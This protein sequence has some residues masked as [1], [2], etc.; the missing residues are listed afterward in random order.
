[1]FVFGIG[2]GAIGGEWTAARIDQRRTEIL[3]VF[4]AACELALA[5]TG[6]FSQSYFHSLDGLASQVEGMHLGIAALLL[7]GPALCMGASLPLA[8]RTTGSHKGDES[9]SLYAY[10]MSVNGIGATMGVLFTV[11]VGIELLGLQ[12]MERLASVANLGAAAFLVSQFR[13]ARSPQL[14]KRNVLVPN[15]PQFP[16]ARLLLAVFTSGFLAMALQLLWLR[17]LDIAT[18]SNPYVF[19][20][21]LGAVIAGLTSGSFAYNRGLVRC[22]TTSNLILACGLAGLVVWPVVAVLTS[23]TSVWVA[24]CLPFIFVHSAL[25]ATIVPRILENTRG[26]SDFGSPTPHVHLGYV[27]AANVTG[28]ALGPLVVG[29]GLFNVLGITAISLVLG[30]GYGVLLIILQAPLAPVRANNVVFTMLAALIALGYTG[31]WGREMSLLHFGRWTMDADTFSAVHTS[32][33]GTIAITPDRTVYGNGAY[34]GGINLN[35][36]GPENTNGIDRAYVASRL[37]NTSQAAL[38][39]GLS[40]GSWATVLADSPAITQLDVIEINPAYGQMIQQFAPVQ[41]LLS[42]P[43]IRIHWADA[44]LWLQQHDARYGLIVMNTTW[45]WRAMIT[46]LIAR[47]FLLELAS[48]LVPGG[49]LFFNTTYSPEILKTTATVFPYIGTYGNFVA[50]SFSP[51]P[52]DELTIL[53]RQEILSNLASSPIV[54]DDRPV[55]EFN[56]LRSGAF[57]FPRRN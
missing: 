25:S 36:Q 3:Y 24:L 46:Q 29:L 53:H 8:C 17:T 12:S 23:L 27:Y 38:L 56:L 39:I 32:R 50:A 37:A 51:L 13:R 2:L 52:D 14:P 55:T 22:L 6:W 20:L 9:A 30:L 49:I 40:L 21:V 15:T 5:L 45:H 41:P 43:D 44:R 48:H 47:E 42:N 10:Y 57:S 1:M 33:H 11:L 35:P 7:L 16:T 34:D 31:L 19:G 28:A 18:G 26:G 54:T 4:F